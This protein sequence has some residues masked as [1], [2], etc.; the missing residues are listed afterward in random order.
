M[1]STPIREDTLGELFA[2]SKLRLESEGKVGTI[3]RLQAPPH[4]NGTVAGERSAPP[5]F[6]PSDTMTFLRSHQDDGG[7]PR[8]RQSREEVPAPGDVPGGGDGRR[9]PEYHAALH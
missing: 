1:E 6:S 9:L 2:K 8:H 5:H 4:L 3:Y 7:L